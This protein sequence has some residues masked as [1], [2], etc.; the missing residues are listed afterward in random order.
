MILSLF[1]A[2][3][4]M[5]GYGYGCYDCALFTP[6]GPFLKSSDSQA[7]RE[8]S[9]G[10][11]YV[12]VTDIRSNN[13]KGLIDN[14]TSMIEV[15]DST[16]VTQHLA[17]QSGSLKGGADAEIGVSWTPQQAGDYQLRTFIISNLENPQILSVVRESE[18]SIGL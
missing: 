14:F 3:S 16:G 8:A 9:V 12:I 11:Q 4:F 5:L 6:S 17:W 13:D 10:Q 2:G 15:R 1:M 7:L 18:I